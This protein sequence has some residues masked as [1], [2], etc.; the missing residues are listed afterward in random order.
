MKVAC[1]TLCF[2]RLPLDRALKTM[3]ELEFSKVDATISPTGPHLTPA[4][5]AADPA[6]CARLLRY[7]SS[8]A[9]A[10]LNLEFEPNLDHA[11][12]VQQFEA[13]CKMA[14][15][16]GV[17]TL[18][19]PAAPSNS[20]MEAEVNRLKEL[21]RL[22]EPYGLVVTVETRIGTMTELPANAV[23]LCEKVPGLG[24]TLDPSH[25][26]CGPNQNKSYDAVYPFVKHVHL[27]DTGLSPDKMQVRVGQGEIEYSRIITQLEKHKYNRVLT[28]EI[29]DKPENPFPME[30]EVRKLK[31]LLESLAA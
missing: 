28:V 12:F 30:T 15:N 16:L 2:G 6:R 27:R 14:R 19:L 10:A 18:T 11:T 22:A 1:S 8:V 20:D 3:E 5:V 4:E 24:L 25:Y 26:I 29:V 9:P 13:I 23:K 17:A 21:V 7:T 31:F